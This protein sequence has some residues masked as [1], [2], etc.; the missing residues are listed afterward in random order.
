MAGFE[1]AWKNNED[2]VIYEISKVFDLFSF[3]PVLYFHCAGTPVFCFGAREVVKSLS[4]VCVL[5]L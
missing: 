1:P 3:V 4:A 5:G 2:K